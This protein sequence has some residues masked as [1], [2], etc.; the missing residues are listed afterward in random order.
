MHRV[1]RLGGTIAVILW[2]FAGTA[3]AGGGGG[4]ICLVDSPSP[5][6]RTVLVSDNC[7]YQPETVIRAGEVVR[8]ELRAA[9]APHTV[10]FDVGLD[11]G[12]IREPLAI[13]FNEPGTYEYFCRY[14]GGV[15]Y[16]MAGTVRVK[17]PARNHVGEP[18]FDLVEGELAAGDAQSFSA[19]AAEVQPV[20]A[21]AAPGAREVLVR[22]DRGTA[23]TLVLAALA[24]GAAA[25][26][27][28]RLGRRPG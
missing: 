22:L 3:N 20:A 15:G 21:T 1:L 19:P 10:T 24:F 4:G 11:G 8:W 16:G 25:G 28:G 6:A 2:A 5:P 7:F 14:H 9:A 27:I 17:G 13:R 18:S 23:V 26:L 12:D